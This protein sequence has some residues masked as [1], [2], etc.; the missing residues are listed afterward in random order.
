M[1]YHVAK[2]GSDQNDGSL[3]HPFL[4]IER[5]NLVLTSGDKVVV[6][7]GIYRELVA[8]RRGGRDEKNRIV[9]EAAEGE[10]VSIRGSEVVKDWKKLDDIWYCDIDNSMFG[11]FNPFDIPLWGDWFIY[12]EDRKVHQAEVYLDGKSMFEVFSLQEVGKPQKRDIG[13]SFNASYKEEHLRDPEFSLYVWFAEVGETRT[14]I[15]ANFQKEDP[16]SHLV[17]IT[18]RE[19]VFFP[20]TH[21]VNYITVRGFELC[22]AATPWAPP[23]SSQIGLIGPNWAKGWIIEDCDIHSAKCALVSLG[24]EESSGDNDCTRY[25]HK[26]GYNV[27][28]ESVFDCLQKGWNRD[29]VGSHIVR[30]NRI[31]D[32][33]ENG[34]VGHMG[35]AFSEIY[36]NE[37]YNIDTK[38]EFFG[39]EIAAIKF[40]AP[41]DTH[42]HDNYIHSSTLG[43]WIDWQA[44]G[45]RLSSNV[46]ADNGI[47]LSLEVCH[48]PFVIDNNI[49]ASRYNMDNATQGGAFVNNL[50]MG[51]FKYGKVLD[52]A[53]PYHFAHSTAVK[54]VALIYL[55]DEKFINNLFLSSYGYP[56]E[57]AAGTGR[58]SDYPSSLEEYIEEVRGIGTVDESNFGKVNSPVYLK[59][60]VY[61]GAGASEKDITSLKIEEP[62][63]VRIVDDG[64]EAY[65]EIEVPCE[66]SSFEV[67]VLYSYEL[68]S[69]RIVDLPYEDGQGREIVFDEPL[70]G[71]KREG[72]S[73]PGPFGSLSPGLNR[74]V[75]WKR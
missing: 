74:F 19:S 42:I 26:S 7:E 70:V 12:P 45:M 57:Y 60:N 38:Y 51:A 28:L 1:I 16:L 18:V 72:L 23:T 34:I 71:D 48:G 2:H 36:G 11:D 67:P 52:R 31:H 62:C 40:H 27:Q 43:M 8:P 55:G 64:G 24:K 37:I 75:F 58:F 69:P 53:T 35:C 66:L 15:Y 59:N 3:E 44:Q 9:Y 33:G 6:H 29:M 25:A 39:Y 50:F 46:F 54:G 13:Y 41:I 68:A 73:A 10:K 21:F 4:T 63:P 47:D 22:Q 49:F 5:A 14:R 32:A 61:S 56:K 17:E 30:N 65:I 20:K